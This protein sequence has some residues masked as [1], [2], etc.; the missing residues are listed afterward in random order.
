MYD[1]D[2]G[3]FKDRR[4]EEQEL[5]KSLAAFDDPSKNTKAWCLEPDYEGVLR[6]V[7]GEEA[8]QA[9]CQKYPG[10]SKAV[11]ARLIAADADTP[12]LPAA[13]AALNWL[14]D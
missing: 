2:S 5:N 12:I 3:S 9:L 1:R 11:R 4:D 6:Q 8:Y 13:E 14:K 7:L 10:V